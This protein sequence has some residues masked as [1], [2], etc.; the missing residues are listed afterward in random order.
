MASL[1]AASDWSAKLG[2]TPADGYPRREGRI[3]VPR[4]LPALDDESGRRGRRAAAWI[5]RIRVALSPRRSRHGDSPSVPAEPGV[6][7]GS[8]FAVM[9]ALSLGDVRAWTVR[10]Q[11]AAPPPDPTPVGRVPGGQIAQGAEADASG[12]QVLTRGPIHEAFAAPVVHDPR[13]A[14]VIPKQPPDPIQE[15]PP[16]QK[17]AGQNVQWIPGYWSW[18]RLAQRLP[19]GQRHLARA[20]A[21]QPV[22]PR[23]LAP[24][25]RGIPVGLRHVDAG[26]AG[27][28]RGQGQ[29]PGAGQPS[30]LPPPPRA[31]KRARPRR[32]PAPTSPGRPGYWSWQG[33]ATPGGPASG[34]PSSPTGSGCRRTTSGPPAAISSS[35]DTGTCRSPTAG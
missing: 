7:A 35:P 26:S 29:A 27:P 17:P 18:D 32:S 24:G 8:F 13:P 28:S 22:G 23:L 25:R 9:A 5:G 30:Y 10:A 4:R 21:E 1:L 19:L 2:Q 16:D 33:A 3:P 20:A 6:A 11:D 31:S 15:M 14:P 12:G 34:R